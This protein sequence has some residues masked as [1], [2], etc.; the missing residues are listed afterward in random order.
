MS[1]WIFQDPK[2]IEKHGP[3]KAAW[4]VG[5]YD[6]A[7]KRKS[8][9]CG[10][11]REGRRNADALRRKLDAELLLDTYEDKSKATWAEFR[12]E[13]ESK[14]IVKKAIRTRPEIRTALDHFERIVCPARMIGITTKVID[15]FV[16]KRRQERGKHQGDVISPATV[17]K[18]L[19]H[20]KCALRRAQRWG[21]LAALPEFD[22][23]RE[24]GKLPTF[25][26]PE[27]FAAIYGACDNAT[28]PGTATYS[29]GDWW[30][31]LIVMAYMTGW[32]VSELLALRRTD[33]DMDAGTAI[34]RAADNK[35][36]RDDRANLH[37][38]VIEHL[39]RLMGFGVFVFAW[40][41]DRRT[42]QTEFARI[43]EAAGIKLACD[44]A[45]KHTRFC[46]VYGFHDLRRAFATLN[47]DRLT[48]D[49]LQQLMRHRSYQ[50]TKVYI[51]LARQMDTAVAALHVPEVLQPKTA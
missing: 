13:Y 29:A 11:G 37:P 6:P 17:N 33:L 48:A 44:A 43:Q 7:G 41:H 49:A 40:P 22:F 14:V 35:G 4:M 27:H 20:I 15:D 31:A 46:H 36:K 34:T 16:A 18:D 10:S 47:A 38:V 51:N 50:T 32:R 21:Y 26:S 42:L 25:V 3:A 5:W 23:E 19:R 8:K 9:S 28:M 2:Q 30:R 24:P 39:R 12:T 45:H 1:A